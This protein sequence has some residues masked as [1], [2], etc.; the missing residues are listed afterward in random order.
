WYKQDKRLVYKIHGSTKNIFTG[1][2]TRNSLI[3][4]LSAFGRNK[5]GKNVFQIEPFKRQVFTNLTKNRTLIVMGYSGSDDFDIVPTLMM[6]H[7]IE[8]IFWINH[9]QDYN[10]KENF[11]EIRVSNI[12]ENLNMEKVNEI[13]IKIKLMN[14]SIPIYRIDANT[15]QILNSISIF[16]QDEQKDEDNLSIQSW[17]NKIFGRDRENMMFL[18]PFEIY[19]TFQ[20]YNDSIRIGNRLIETYK[21]LNKKRSI[22]AI[23]NDVGI[24]YFS[25]NKHNEAL[26]HLK[27]SLIIEKELRDPVGI[28]NSLTNIGDVYLAQ[29]KNDIA[30]EMFKKALNQI[31]HIEIILNKI[32]SLSKSELKKSIKIKYPTIYKWMTDWGITI[33]RSDFGFLREKAHAYNKIAEVYIYKLK[34]NIAISYLNKAVEIAEKL[35]SLSEKAMYI[36]NLGLS[37]FMQNKFDKA[38]E[39][40]L[41][42]IKIV[43][44]LGELS[45]MY[46]TRQFIGELYSKQRNY[47]EALRYFKETLQIAEKTRNYLWISNEYLN[48]GKIHSYESNLPLAIETL[49][50]ALEILKKYKLE[51][52][53]NKARILYNIGQ[54]YHLSGQKSLAL[55][56]LKEALQVLESDGL[57]TSSYAL[58]VK[59]S[60]KDVKN[61]VSL[62]DYV[63]KYLDKDKN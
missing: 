63:M 14:P 42:A 47:S 21:K 4:T 17:L 51:D 29:K 59:Q 58:S 41:E 53:G 38:M 18:M 49:T 9:V 26:E 36:S 55:E 32:Q 28:A 48:I 1:K 12:E 44:A 62:H 61:N 11:S 37:Y 23:H 15:S 50:Q 33:D 46:F 8:Q 35:G 25:L 7:D 6:L 40:Y 60:I 30:L 19:G 24:A 13:L 43:D 27:K 52:L 10:F 3:A 57:G 54:A 45:G 34:F 56:H 20:Y 39:Q 2:S 22:A 31:E 5:E 16:E